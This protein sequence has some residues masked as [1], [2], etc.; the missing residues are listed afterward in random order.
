MKVVIYY[1][2][3]SLVLL[4]SDNSLFFNLEEIT[5]KSRKRAKACHK[6]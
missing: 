1:M 2:L 4:H 6:L 3:M 5:L